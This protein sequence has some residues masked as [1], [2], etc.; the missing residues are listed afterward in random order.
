MSLLN[1]IET[2]AIGAWTRESEWGYP[3]VLICHTVGMA[4]VVGA[5]MAFAFRIFLSKSDTRIDWFELVFKL[6]WIGFAINLVSGLILFTGA[7]HRFAVHPAFQIKLASLAIGAVLIWFLSRRVQRLNDAGAP[8]N[9]SST[10]WLSA[11]AILFWFG[12]IAAGRLM[13]YIR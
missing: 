13:A 6:A 2:S 10:R 4:I 11:A 12:A 8:T 9:A 3:I 1:D 5:V 7:A